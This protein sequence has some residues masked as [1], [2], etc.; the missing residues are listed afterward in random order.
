MNTLN[1]PLF[2]L[3][4]VLFP[5]GL[6]PLKVFEP[7]YLSM[8]SDCLKQDRGFGVCLIKEGKEAGVAAK[9][10]PLGTLARIIDWDRN[11][12]GQL[13]LVAE[14]TQ[15]FRVQRSAVRGDQLLV[16]DVTLLENERTLDLP[17][18]YAGLAETL[19]KIL[20][21][22]GRPFS[23]MD[24]HLGNASWVSARLVE[25]L[26]LPLLEK[27]SLLESSDPV[28]RLEYLAARMDRFSLD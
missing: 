17:N 16:A 24:M 22:L 9:P 12:A 6:L 28:S 23:S 26:P 5:G 27:H 4:T 11:E 14:G 8:V 19:E 10:Y 18:S 2:P 7:R 25:L 1:I 3:Y 13:T 21:Q 20:L 15:R